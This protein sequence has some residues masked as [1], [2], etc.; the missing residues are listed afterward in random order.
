MA[1]TQQ[2][3]SFDHVTFKDETPSFH[4]VLLGA[5][6]GGCVMF[7]CLRK[8]GVSLVVLRGA[9]VFLVMSLACTWAVHAT[10]V[11]TVLVNVLAGAWKRN[12]TL[13]GCL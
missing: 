10:C 13:F 12:V 11:A 1:V 3:T 4:V 7:F 2:C 8:S 9:Q 6:Q 5:A